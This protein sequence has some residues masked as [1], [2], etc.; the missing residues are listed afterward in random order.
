MGRLGG[1]MD[2]EIKF[3]FLE[4]LF[5][6]LFVADIEIDRDEIRVFFLE[7]VIVPLGA[8]FF[9]E[10]IAAHVV[11]DAHNQKFFFSEKSHRF[12]PN[13]PS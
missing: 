6:R 2:D 9:A 13:Q 8:G 11:V 10:K 3:D 12:G 4:N 5:D 1:G 7:Q